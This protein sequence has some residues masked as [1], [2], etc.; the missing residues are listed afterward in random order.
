LAPAR[1]VESE[2]FTGALQAGA[3]VYSGSAV[4]PAKNRPPR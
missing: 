4:Q 3:G 2:Q 1:S